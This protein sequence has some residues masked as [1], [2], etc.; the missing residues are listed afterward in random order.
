MAEAIT[1]ILYLN[2]DVKVA[3]DQ[4]RFHHQLYPNVFQFERGFNE[5]LLNELNKT[6]KHAIEP[7]PNRLCIIS[8]VSRDANGKLYSHTDYR[9]G[10]SIDGE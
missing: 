9:K 4:W 3:I 7:I 5:E 6:Y 1:R 10:G 2:Q 8:A